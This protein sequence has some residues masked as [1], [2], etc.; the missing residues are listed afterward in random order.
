MSAKKIFLGGRPPRKSQV[1]EAIVRQIRTGALAPDE[2]LATVRDMSACFGVS[3]SVIQGAMKE[4]AS[5]GFVEC[6][7]KSGFYVTSKAGRGG[8]ASSEPP[9]VG[10]RKTEGRI[11]L[12]FCHHSDLMWLRTSK[13]YDAIRERQL[14]AL[15]GYAERHPDMYFQFE[16]AEVARRFLACHPE[17][18]KHARALISSGHLE[19]GAAL[20]IPDLN[21]VCGEAIFRNLELGQEYWRELAG[22]PAEMANLNDAFG[23]CAQLPQILAQSGVRLLLPGRRPNAPE[24]FRG[25]EPFRWIGADGGS[26]VV[27]LP[28]TAEIT[29]LGYTHNVPLM[30]DYQTRLAQAV[31]TLKGLNGNA[32]VMYITEEGELLESVFAIIAAANRS[33]GKP[34]LMGSNAQYAQTLEWGSLPIYRGEFNP[35]FTGCYTSRIGV[36]QRIRAAENRLFQAETVAALTG[37]PAFREAW[38]ELVLCQF[39]DAICGCHV[40]AVNDEL[41]ERLT[42]AMPELPSGR[43]LFSFVNTTA[44]QV[45]E[46]HL[47]APPSTPAQRD[48]EMTVFTMALPAFGGKRLGRMMKGNV[49]KPVPAHFENAHYCVDFTE[50]FPVIRWKDS[51]SPFAEKRFGEILFRRDAGSM[52][53]EQYLTPPL[54]QEYQDEHLVSSIAGPVFH[55]VVTEGEL[56]PVN[57]RYHQPV[58]GWPGFGRLTYRKE[59]RFYHALDWFELRLH[60]DWEGN[61]TRVSIRFPT[62]VRPQDA[63]CTYETPCGSATRKPYF[64]VPYNEAD[65]FEPLRQSTDYGTAHGDWPALNWV[66]LADQEK[67]LAVANTGT[68]GHS[69]KDGGIEV[70]L[71]RSG[72]AT[73]DGALTPMGGAF[74]NGPHDY[75][76]AFR[77]ATAGQLDRALELG[78]LLN[79]P[80][81]LVTERIPLVSQLA[82]DA[83][84]VAIS[85]LRRLQD[86]TIQA[87]LYE[88]L[89]MATTS[90]LTGQLASRLQNASFT[91]APFEIK[92]VLFPCVNTVH[93]QE[94]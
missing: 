30:Y 60:L 66:C 78:T 70:A 4:L 53:S 58:T 93:N 75:R 47:G 35:V 64:E 20:C 52:W 38:R 34:I 21:M 49:A 25:G 37:G 16:Q 73:M 67:G 85:T 12:H 17:Y 57:Q 92:S 74:D 59:W 15:F 68:P 89:G 3:I 71:L 44:P 55:A 45:V 2:R 82:W 94:N 62:T 39:H 56:H 41:Q 26:E 69:L 54:G 40:D 19:L 91:F 50:A 10:D 31:E 14:L 63:V 13:E 28:R 29:H 23:M 24:E 43:T 77:T 76:F 18:V 84:N 88:A 36:K 87:R 80:P 86:G 7:G 32:N 90:R 79:R 9:S 48:G 83:P 22:H 5:G 1:V 46:S 27:V 81:A 42:C 6:R 51:A 61:N 65:S 33:G 8:N 72:T 11:F